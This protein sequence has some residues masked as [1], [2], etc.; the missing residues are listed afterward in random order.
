MLPTSL[1]TGPTTVCLFWSYNHYSSLL[2]LC[3]PLMF[4]T[5]DFTSVFLLKTIF[6]CKQLRTKFLIQSKSGLVSSTIVHVAGVRRFTKPIVLVEYPFCY[7]GRKYM[8][9]Q[10]ILQWSLSRG[11]QILKATG[12]WRGKQKSFQYRLKHFITDGT[13]EFRIL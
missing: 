8:I 6:R 2:V 1:A 9:H 11:I 7:V 4:I 12:L 10:I 3:F 5:A 13:A